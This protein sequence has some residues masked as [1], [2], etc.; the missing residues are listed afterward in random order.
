MTAV[1]TPQIIAQR[2]PGRRMKDAGRVLP[3]DGAAASPVKDGSS[4]EA[5]ISSTN[6]VIE[7]SQF[8]NRSIHC[9]VANS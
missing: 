6:R 4:M 7:L 1:A 5:A 9:R 8:P 3:K 2:G